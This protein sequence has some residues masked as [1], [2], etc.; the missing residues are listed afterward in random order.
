MEKAEIKKMCHDHMHRY[1]CVWME[2]GSMHDGIIES[3]D[4]EHLRL[5]VPVGSE[6]MSEMHTPMYA[7]QGGPCGC[8]PPPC[9]DPRA[10][11]YSRGF[12][13]FGGHGGYPHY[14]GYPYYGGGYYPG[15][16]RF[17]PLL[18]PLVGLTALSVLPLL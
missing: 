17:S 8:P 16:R 3:V 15:R 2:D 12:G 4:E 18:L 7:Y 9:G 1:V 10:F 11:Q 13:G 14:G 6:H 5:A